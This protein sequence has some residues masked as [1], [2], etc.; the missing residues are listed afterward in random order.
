MASQG[1]FSMNCRQASI[2]TFFSSAGRA[3]HAVRVHA[4]GEGA[5]RDRQSR[6]REKERERGRE[7]EDRETESRS[8]RRLQIQQLIFKKRRNSWNLGLL[9][10]AGRWK[11][12][13]E[14]REG[15]GGTPRSVWFASVQA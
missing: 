7:E 10:V 12:R 13:G 8:H 4:A 6:H 5:A 15:G 3:P 14:L 9:F 2:S 11:G 1:E